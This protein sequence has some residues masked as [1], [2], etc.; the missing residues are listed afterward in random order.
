[1]HVQRWDT[2]VLDIRWS[3]VC[4]TNK[5]NK[6]EDQEQEEDAEVADPG[7]RPFWYRAI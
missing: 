6:Y 4:K 1:M 5:Q 2:I 3:A 7:V